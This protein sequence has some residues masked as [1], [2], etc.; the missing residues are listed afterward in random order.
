MAKRRLKLG[1]QVLLAAVLPLV[2]AHRAQA[3]TVS[4]GDPFL[5]HSW[6]AAWNESSST[7]FDSLQA[8]I[9]GPS[10]A[11]FESPGLF[12]VGGGWG[13]GSVSGDQKAVSAAGAVMSSLQFSTRFID[14]PTPYTPGNQL[15][16]D[17]KFKKDGVVVDESLWSFDN[18]NGWVD[19][20]IGV[21]DGGASLVLLGLSALGLVAFRKTY[22]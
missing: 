8:T 13:V 21:P 15:F 9:L 14:D 10:S 7:S 19:P 18:V 17:F 3:T 5:G 22:R 2:I 1:I 11:K 4:W 20:P 16:L 12:N 6:D